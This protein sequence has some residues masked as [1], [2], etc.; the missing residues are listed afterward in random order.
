MSVYLRR[1]KL[2]DDMNEEEVEQTNNQSQDASTQQPDNS[3]DYTKE[4]AIIN[5]KIAE[6]ERRFNA[7][8]QPL[9]NQR[10]AIMQAAAKAGISL[11]TNES[12]SCKFSAKLFESVIKNS[13]T[14][15]LINLIDSTF[16]SLPDL[17]YYMDK[18]GCTSLAKRLLA[19][20]NDQYWNDGQN[21]WNDVAEFIRGTLGKANISL[22]TKEMM[23]FVNE[24]GNQMQ[25]HN[26]FIW[27]FG[28]NPKQNEVVEEP[29][30]T[31]QLSEPLEEPEETLYQEP[32]DEVPDTV[33]DYDETPDVQEDA[34]FFP[35][36]TEDDYDSRY[37]G[38][39]HPD[40]FPEY[41]DKS[42]PLY[43]EDDELYEGK[44]FN[45]FN[46]RK[47]KEIVPLVSLQKEIPEE[48]LEVI[49]ECLRNSADDIEKEMEERQAFPGPVIRDYFK[50][51]FDEFW[52]VFFNYFP[53]R[54]IW[55]NENGQ[56]P[57]LDLDNIWRAWGI[58]ITSLYANKIMTY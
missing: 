34:V 35:G 43:G 49:T 42:G 4:F 33:D 22:S 9:I 15:E 26:M 58:Q 31:K 44:L 10:T 16:S 7:E 23:K 56:N 41:D 8:K 36:E 29:V 17:S 55:Y 45:I 53:E 48:I 37:F 57:R 50:Y 6:L 54:L 14:D 51:A 27:I 38:D 5:A 19:F 20:L 3:R 21:H 13:K 46:R 47:P 18:K 2:S 40:D 30:E 28:N 32:L 25:G 1:P 39:L 12:V 24:L 11:T 52:D